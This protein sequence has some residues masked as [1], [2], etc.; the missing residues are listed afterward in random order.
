MYAYVLQFNTHNAFLLAFK[1]SLCRWIIRWMFLFGT[2]PW[3][4]SCQ[5]K[6]LH[7][8][9]RCKKIHFDFDTISAVITIYN[10]FDWGKSASFAN[11][12]HRIEVQLSQPNQTVWHNVSSKLFYFEKNVVALWRQKKTETTT[13]FNGSKNNNFLFS[14]WTLFY[15]DFN[16]YRIYSIQM[17]G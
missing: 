12:N 10:W 13:F 15:R 5:F 4:K 2:C 11:R 16:N 7:L 14:R 3:Y 8:N 9:G 6:Q 17:I 1:L